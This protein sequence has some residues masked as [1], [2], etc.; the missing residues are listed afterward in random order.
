M[1]RLGFVFNLD[2]CSDLRGCMVSCKDKTNAFLGAHYIETLTNIS[3]DYPR[4]NTY[5]VPVL[6]NHCDKPSCVPA[7]PH[8]VFAKRDDGIVTV[9]D[10]SV[11]ES[12]DSKACVEA[13]PY[14]RIFLDPKDGRVGKCD[15]CVDLVDEGKAPACAARCITQS[16]LFGDFDDPNSVVAQT[17]AAWG[18]VGYVHQLKPETGN[19]PAV[20]YLLSKKQWEDTEK[21]YSPAWQNEQ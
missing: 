21:L 16:I 3:M 10:T 18:E 19:G 8:G 6:C 13:C 15:M 5:F 11:C 20:Y 4:P 14:D 1:T 12:C 9:A 7:C 2:T 17:I